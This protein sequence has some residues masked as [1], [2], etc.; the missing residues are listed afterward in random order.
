MH[1][2]VELYFN[3]FQHAQ[4]NQN[5][6]DRNLIFSIF[7]FMP[8]DVGVQMNKDNKKKHQIKSGKVNLKLH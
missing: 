5:T 6:K 3:V 1:K 7:C 4:C 8:Y 2:V